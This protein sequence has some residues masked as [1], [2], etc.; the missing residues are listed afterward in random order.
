MSKLVARTSL[1][2][3]EVKWG[4]QLATKVFCLTSTAAIAVFLAS[5]ET[6]VAK[7]VEREGR[8]HPKASE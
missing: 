2:N 4:M 7:V 6:L 3:T 8:S 5:L 1:V